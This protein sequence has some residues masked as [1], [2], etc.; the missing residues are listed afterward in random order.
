MEHRELEEDTRD[1]R[2]LLALGAQQAGPIERVG[3]RSLL[4]PVARLSCGASV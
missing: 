4:A 3:E 2:S 1:D